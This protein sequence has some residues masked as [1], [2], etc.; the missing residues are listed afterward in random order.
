MEPGPVAAE[1]LQALAPRRHQLPP[2]KV[3]A[4]AAAVARDGPCGTLLVQAT[5]NLR[6]RRR[7]P[8]ERSAGRPGMLAALAEKAHRLRRARAKLPVR[9]AMTPL[10][11][12]AMDTM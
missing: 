6:R 8:A 11:T 5:T 10:L 3:P 9:L 2:P 7:S 1:A 12:L 4:Q